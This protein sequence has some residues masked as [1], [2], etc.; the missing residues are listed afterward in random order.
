MKLQILLSSTLILSA[1]GS[2][3]SRVYKKQ[4]SESD[5]KISY[6]NL[7]TGAIKT[8]FQYQSYVDKTLENIECDL[9]LNSTIKLKLSNQAKIGLGAFSTEIIS[10]QSDDLINAI[11]LTEGKSI[12]YNLNCQL[13][14]D[15]GGEYLRESSVLYLSPNSTKLYR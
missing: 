5:I 1:C 8:R 12:Q 9:E 6:L 15:T 11:E 4:R 2:Q 7:Q 14:Y 3:Q 13:D 10:F